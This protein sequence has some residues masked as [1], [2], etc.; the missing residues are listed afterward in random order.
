MLGD[1][2]LQMSAD[3]NFKGEIYKETEGDF[4]VGFEL[5]KKERDLLKHVS[6]K[7]I[8]NC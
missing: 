1:I 3:S 5:L 6:I 8:N 7:G 2:F 4:V